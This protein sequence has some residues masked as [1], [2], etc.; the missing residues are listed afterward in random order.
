MEINLLVPP[1][2][3]EL[4]AE[5]TRLRNSMTGPGVKWNTLAVW[6]GNKIPKYLWSY[7]KDELKKHDFTW[8]SFLKLLR[9][10]TDG[11]VLWFYDKLDWNTYVR[12]TIELVTGPLGKHISE[13]A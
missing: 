5:I 10:R 3:P 2:S 7:W 11:A 12:Q 13:I 6:Y 4:K 1:E 8:Q 9:H